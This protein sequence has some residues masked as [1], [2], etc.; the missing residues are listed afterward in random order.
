VVG[1]G[2]RFTGPVRVIDA[3]YPRSDF[4]SGAMRELSPQKASGWSERS[5]LAVLPLILLGNSTDDQGI[6]LGFAD[7]LVTQLGN[8]KDVDV[9]PISAVLGAPLEAGAPEI[10]SRLGVRFVVRGGIQM[11]KGLWRLSMEMFD[12]HKE[13]VCFRRKCDLD[14]DRLPEVEDEIAKQIAVALK[15][16]IRAGGR[17]TP[18]AIQQTTQWHTQ[19]SYEASGSVLPVTQQRSNW[20]LSI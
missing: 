5:S 2:Y 4:G 3:R 17:A 13:N 16:P 19:N 15:R 11:S 18:R 7:N 1:K 6:C 14:V 9:L 10:A 20:S 8:L 12:V